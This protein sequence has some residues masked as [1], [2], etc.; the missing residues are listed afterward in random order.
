MGGVDP[1]A[2]MYTRH[3][4]YNYTINNPINFID[5]DGRYITFF[6]QGTEYRYT[7]AGVQHEVNGEWT[8]IDSSVRFSDSAIN[9]ITSLFQLQNGGDAGG[10]LIGYFDNQTNNIKIE[11]TSGENHYDNG[12]AYINTKNTFQT[13]T[14]N[15]LENTPL[16]IALGHE[17]AHGMDSQK[18]PDYFY[19]WVKGK[20]KEQ[21]ISN[22]EK[23]ASH[24]ENKIRAEWNLSL[25]ASYALTEKN[26][27]EI[28]TMLVDKFGYSTYFDRREN[29]LPGISGRDKADSYDSI[30]RNTNTRLLN[31]YNY[32]EN[33]K[34]PNFLRL[35]LLWN[36]KYS[37]PK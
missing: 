29:K 20:T 18:N 8:N 14:V 31:R 24:I 25:R 9:I 11:E 13:Y 2:E 35:F 17:M 5:P 27:L 21:D 26:G 12:A 4:P 1:F 19:P 32:Y 23:Y 15:G 10:S 16:F 33:R 3:S 6:D 7:R 22:S 37:P 30:M 34:Q 36:Y 28:R